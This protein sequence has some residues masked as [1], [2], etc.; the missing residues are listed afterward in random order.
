M[1]TTDITPITSLSTWWNDADF[2]GK[3]YCQLK[4][5]GDL[6][7]TGTATHKERT[8]ASLTPENAVAVLKALLE[9]YP[10]VEARVKELQHEWDAAEDKLKL[11]GKV[12]RHKEYLIHTNAIGDFDTLLQQVENWDKTLKE[13]IENNYREKLAITEKAEK[14]ALEGESWKETTQALKEIG[15]Q[16]K[17]IG[18]VDKHRNE[19]LWNRIETARNNFFERKRQYQEDQGKDMLQNLDLKM[20]LVEKAEAAAAS[21]N[22]KDTTEVFRQLMEDW[23]KIGRTIHDK[24]EALWNRFI[25]AKNNF[26]ERKRAHFELIQ[27]E[28]E[29]NYSIKL[30]LVERAEAMKDSTEWGKTAQAYSDL[31]EEWKNAGRVP[32]EKADELW[33]RLNAAKEFFFQN[34]KQHQET[35]RITL[36]DNYAQKLGLLKRAEELKHSNHWREA[37]EEINE[38]MTEWKKI[39]GV[40]R[41]HANTIWEQFIAARKF[42]F[43]RKDADRE[44]RKEQVKKQAQYKYDKTRS[45]LGQLEQELK[46]ERERLEDFKVALE[47]VT[48]GNKEH[49][50][51]AHLQK[52]ITQSEVKIKHKEEKIREAGTQLQDM[53]S[54]KAPEDSSA[55]GNAS[56]PDV[57]S[58]N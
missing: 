9:K 38:L 26:F 12:S 57:D 16:W 36:E 13:L 30:A 58:N 44:R 55:P 39:G 20:E 17:A 6:V 35:Q 46:E 14:L 1:T 19:D 24:N 27:A 34:K 11:I 29:G 31:T 56:T 23:K 42:F 43:D 3:E 7:L 47:N 53:D 18:F 22:W 50:L 32:I 25:M 33:N 41:E 21:E 37:T 52:L 2:K 54:K 48:P 49:E 51:R 28:Q 8:I 4:E 15:D 5:N 45:F 10:E 40:P